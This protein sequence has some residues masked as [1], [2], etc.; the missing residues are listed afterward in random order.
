MS[1]FSDDVAVPQLEVLRTSTKSEDY[2]FFSEE[3]RSCGSLAVTWE[4]A[5]DA[6]CEVLADSQ[7]SAYSKAFIRSITTREEWSAAL[8]RFV[9]TLKRAY[10]LFLWEELSINNM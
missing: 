7:L 4:G 10:G 9:N 8:D 5:S 3:G 2:I 6:S 1:T